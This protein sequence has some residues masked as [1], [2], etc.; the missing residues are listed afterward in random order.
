MRLCTICLLCCVPFV[1][2][3]L[4]IFLQPFVPAEYYALVCTLATVLLQAI[5]APVLLM[6][7]TPV[8]QNFPRIAWGRWDEWGKCSGSVSPV[9]VMTVAD[10]STNRMGHQTYPIQYE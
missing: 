5:D 3:N 1:S 9:Q 7:S 6:L 4:L 2:I 8:R 10:Y